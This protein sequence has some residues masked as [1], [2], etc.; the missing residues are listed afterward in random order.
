M[1]V[2]G[3]HPTAVPLPM[4][5]EVLTHR[6]A[7]GWRTC[8]CRARSMPGSV[9]AVARHPFT[10]QPERF[11]RRKIPRTDSNDFNPMWPA[12]DARKIY[13][14][15]DRDGAITLFSYDTGSKKVSQAID[16]SD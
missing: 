6:T 3:V 16:Q 14:L 1:A 7:R 11:E 15:S 10:L 13:F 9:I 2:D 4:A 8:R 12:G 5:Y